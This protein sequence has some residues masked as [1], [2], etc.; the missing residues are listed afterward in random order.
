MKKELI[1]EVKRI[2]QIMNINE[3]WGSVF[4][5]SFQTLMSSGSILSLYRVLDSLENIN[6]ID[7][8]LNTSLRRE[9]S[10][11]ADN[12]ED[13]LDTIAKK[14]ERISDQSNFNKV[15]DEFMGALDSSSATKISDDIK[16]IEN[17][18][19][20]AESDSIKLSTT[21]NMDPEM[22]KLYKKRLD[23]VT[24]KGSSSFTPTTANSSLIQTVDSSLDN[25]MN[26]DMFKKQYP[27][28]SIRET[29]IKEA[30]SI[31][32][33]SN[34]QF[35]NLEE[36]DDFLLDMQP[37][38]DA[39]AKRAT[40]ASTSNTYDKI[41]KGREVNE[42]IRSYISEFGK[43][44]EQII[45]TG[46]GIVSKGIEGTGKV[47]KSGRRNVFVIV[48]AIALLYIVLGAYKKLKIMPIFGPLIQGGK[49]E[50]SE[51][52]HDI[53]NIADDAVE[54]EGTPEVVGERPPK[55]ETTPAP[56][57]AETDDTD[58]S[59]YKPDTTIK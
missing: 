20:Q 54:D 35:N 10:T 38:Y 2:K 9:L 13:A 17:A 44:G 15:F 36:V 11:N 49:E 53:I 25:L 48:S 6:A 47:A 1:Q 18:T 31:I 29:L 59:K 8:P 12:F 58:W 19:T 5:P 16:T 39:L 14:I 41:Q 55:E 24:W 33:S 40:D 28:K 3:G 27:N 57:P 26:D 23:S 56:A 30:K 51:I 43:T 4:K 22:A 37:R 32:N 42:K 45:D 50:G 52:V 7:S 46:S 21:A 34:R